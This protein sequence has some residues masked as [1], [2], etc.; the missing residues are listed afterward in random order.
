MSLRTVII[1]D[2][3]R[4]L[5]LIVDYVKQTPSLELIACFQNG[6]EG[7]SFINRNKVDLVLL[8]I[9]LPDISGIELASSF[10]DRPITIF[11]TA[12][13]SH[14]LKGYE[15]DALDY[16]VK[17]ILFPRFI[18]A[19]EKA[20]DK[21]ELNQLRRK[22]NLRGEEPH[23]KN[24]QFMFVK[25]ENHRSKIEFQKIRYLEAYGDYIKIHMVG[26]SIIL[27][28]QTMS[29]ILEK[30]PQNIF[31]RI[32]RSYI[33]NLAHVDVVEKDHVI[34]GNED[35]TIGKSFRENFLALLGKD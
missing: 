26:D 24:D 33:I 10:A 28:L 14:A 23:S 18:K 22:G 2:E 20:I 8:D 12:N 1:E 30:L 31:V 15:V 25:V 9:N 32:H 3:K 27:T 19:I 7:L 35:I 4:A 21:F 13:P 16:L 6:V 17:P 34:V 5:N 29:Q 11:T